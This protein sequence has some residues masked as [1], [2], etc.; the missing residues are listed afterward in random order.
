MK[1]W[2]RHI[3][4]T[5]ALVVLAASA[6]LASG[7]QAAKEDFSRF[8]APMDKPREAAEATIGTFQRPAA[9][10]GSY[11]DFIKAEK[12]LVNIYEKYYG[13]IDVPKPEAAKEAVSCDNPVAVDYFF[14]FSMPSS[15]IHSAVADALALRKKCVNVKMYLRG[16]VDND[17][18]KTIATFYSIAKANPENLPVEIDPARFK[19]ENIRQVPT[20]LVN[21]K[22]FVGDMRLSGIIYNLDAIQEGTV[23]TSYPVREDDLIELFK[24]RAPLLEEKMKEYV[25]SGAVQKKFNLTRY[26]GQFGRAEKRR[27]YYIDPTYILPEDVRDHRGIVLFPKGSAVNPLDSV[28]IGKYIFIDGNRQEEVEMA[29]KGNYREIILVSG[30]ALKLGERYRVQFY[31]ANDDLIQLFQVKRVPLLIEQEGRLIRATEQPV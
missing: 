7:E 23:A 22:R 9:D 6:A 5:S 24:R 21:G 17:L 19:K 29:L 1:Y 4:C 26:D 31:H 11:R 12:E 14:S 15:S 30:D 2:A 25:A 18:K 13:P 10:P 28:A 27:V 3:L 16:L 8:T 20:T